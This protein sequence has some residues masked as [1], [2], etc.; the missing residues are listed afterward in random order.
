MTSGE[1]QGGPMYVIQEGLGPKFKPFAVLFSMAGLVG[2]LP[3]FQANQ[4][5]QFIRDSVFSPLGMFTSDPFIG[6]VVTG[7]SN[8][9]ACC[10][11][12]LWRY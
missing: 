3:M 11:C 2:C 1:L 7:I 5:T 4:L 12:D 9:N 6:N 10:R 8:R